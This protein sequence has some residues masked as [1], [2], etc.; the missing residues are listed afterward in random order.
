MT[1]AWTSLLVLA[2]IPAMADHPSTVALTYRL[3]NPCYRLDHYSIEGSD[4]EV[5]LKDE[6]RGRLCAQVLVERQLELPTRKARQLKR[7]RIYTDGRLWQEQAL[8]PPE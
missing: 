4:L 6:S 2:V 5:F 7:I 8:N 1:T 3:P